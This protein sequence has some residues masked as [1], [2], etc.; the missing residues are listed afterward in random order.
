M[1]DL[2]IAILKTFEN[3]VKVLLNSNIEC[4]FDSDQ[5]NDQNANLEMIYDNLQ[6]IR[7][8]FVEIKS[9]LQR[10]ESVIDS[11]ANKLSPWS[12]PLFPKN[13]VIELDGLDQKPTVFEKKTFAPKPI[14]EDIKKVNINTQS[15]AEQEP[16]LEP[17][18]HPTDVQIPDIIDEEKVKQQNNHIVNL[19]EEEGEEAEE[20]EEEAQEEEVEEEEEKE[21][22]AEEQEEEETE[23]Q[24]EQEEQEEE[25]TEEELE[26]E[27]V[28]FNGKTYYKDDENIVY[29][30]DKNGEIDETPLGRWYEKTKS[31]KYFK[32]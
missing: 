4:V 14:D 11:N 27:E 9:R 20:E 15:S 28:E 22:E 13:V 5:P 30:L 23:E 21:E 32:V 3:T 19:V 18:A 7:Q 16:E 31:I 1:D 25:E 12:T 29:G 17:Y 6:G 8:E 2:K 24:Q 10:I 26:L